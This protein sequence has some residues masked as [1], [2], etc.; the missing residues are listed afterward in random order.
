MQISG[1]LGKRWQEAGQSRHFRRILAA[2]IPVEQGRE[3]TRPCRKTLRFLRF[4]RISPHGILRAYFEKNFMS[5]LP[6]LASL[7]NLVVPAIFAGMLVTCS[8]C[9]RLQFSRN[10]EAM[11]QLDELPPAIKVEAPPVGMTNR[12][13]QTR[14]QERNELRHDAPQEPLQRRRGGSETMAPRFQPEQSNL[15]AAPPYQPDQSNISSPA[16]LAKTA[17]T[18]LTAQQLSPAT[19]TE[20]LRAL[21]QAGITDPIERAQMLADLE[22]TEPRHRG[23]M[24]RMLKASQQQRQP[25]AVAARQAPLERELTPD[26]VAYEPHDEPAPRRRERTPLVQDNPYD[27]PPLKRN[28]RAEQLNARQAQEYA[29]Q[30]SL[31][32]NMPAGPNPV[33]QVSHLEPEAPR[34]SPKTQDVSAK[35]QDPEQLFR[36]ALAGMEKQLKNGTSERTPE[37]AAIRLRLLQALAG[38]RDAALEPVPNLSPAQ[39]E[40]LSQQVYALAALVDQQGNA[41]WARRAG[42]AAEHLQTAADKLSQQAGL[43][44]RNAQLCTEIK[45]F[46][47]YTT[48]AK[49]TFR[50]NQEVLLYAELDRF[51]TRNTERGFH[52]KFHAAYQI[53]DRNGRKVVEKELGLAEEHSPVRRRDYFVSY[54]VRLPAELQS[55]EYTLKLLI[56]DQ[57]GNQVGETSVRLQIEGAPPAVSAA[58]AA[59]LLLPNDRR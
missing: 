55:D 39:Q 53:L 3:R 8:G 35:S 54:L 51:Q 7:R 36:E 6:S 37:I 34:E 47:N 20:Y 59:Q 58:S 30:E 42:L 29:P 9:A 14:Q 56:E 21:D 44:V 22:A 27:D 38:Q 46:G 48:F 52:T 1:K 13:A 19:E 57:L 24:L 41:L 25:K 45:S 31:T 18:G 17:A 23:I 28:P 49:Q 4:A 12:D 15:P 43:L 50:P 33:R 11:R 32:R 16:P 5:P 26:A 10:E 2:S 40:F